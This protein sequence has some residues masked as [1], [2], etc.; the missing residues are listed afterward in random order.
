MYI[1]NQLNLL[2][3]YPHKMRFSPATDVAHGDRC[4]QRFSGHSVWAAHSSEKPPPLPR[5]DDGALKLDPS[6]LFRDRDCIDSDRT[7]NDGAPNTTRGSS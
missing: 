1:L 7:D 5:Q 2:S 4:T 6:E 3:F